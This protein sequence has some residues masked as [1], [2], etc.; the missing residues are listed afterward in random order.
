MKA[1]HTKN[2]LDETVYTCIK[3]NLII[4]FENKG[5][6]EMAYTNAPID[7]IVREEEKKEKELQMQKSLSEF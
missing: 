2:I 1:F 5:G 6:S 4:T 7:K 3:D